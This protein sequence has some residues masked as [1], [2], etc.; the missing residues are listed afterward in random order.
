[1]VTTHKRMNISRREFTHVIDD[2]LKVL[3]HNHIDEES[4]RMFLPFSGPKKAW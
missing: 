3:E 2:I 4:K 1:M